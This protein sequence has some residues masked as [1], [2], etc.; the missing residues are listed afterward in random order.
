LEYVSLI[1]PKSVLAGL[2]EVLTESQKDWA[3][4]K[5]IVELKGL[6]QRQIDLL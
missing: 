2:G 6:I 5:L 3:R 4:A 1:K